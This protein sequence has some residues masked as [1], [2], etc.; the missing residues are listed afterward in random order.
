MNDGKFVFYTGPGT[1]AG[2]ASSITEKMRI[3]AD[4]N[5]GIGTT[6]ASQ[7]LEVAG[8]SPIIRVLATSGNSTLRLTDN[9]VRNWDLKVVDASDYFEVGGTNTTSLIVTGTGK[10]GIGVTN[11]TQ[12]L[13]V[14]GSY[15]TAGDDTGILKIRGGDTGADSQ[16]NFGVSADGGYGWIQTTDV[17]LSNDRSII[18]NPIGGNVG[19]GTTNP[20][21]NGGGLHVYGSGQKGIR[22]SGNS[23]NSYSVEIGCDATKMSYIQTVGTADRGL[24]LYTGN[25]S[26]VVMTL[27]GSSVGIGT[28]IPDAKL[29]VVSGEARIGSA[30]A[31]TTHLNYLNTGTNFISCANNGYTYFR[32]SGTF[33]TIMVIAGGTGNVGIGGSPSYK[34]DVN[35]GSNSFALRL[36]GS[37]VDGPV[38]RF[39][40]TGSTGRIY[41]VGST[42]TTSGAG[43]GFSIYDVTGNSARMLIDA[44][45]N[46]GIGTTA[47][48]AKLDVVGGNV[49]IR[50]D[51]SGGSAALYL[52]NWAGSPTTTMVFG[53]STGDDSSTSLSLNSNI[54][55]ITNYGDP[56]SYI[57]FGTRNNST[58][59]IRMCINQDGNVGIGTTNASNKLE[60]HGGIQLLNSSG[61]TSSATSGS[62]MIIG[63]NTA[64]S[65][66]VTQLRNTGAGLKVGNYGLL[67]D[68]GNVHL[69]STSPGTNIWL[70]CSG[71]GNFIINGQTGATGGVGI[72]TSTMSGYV[73][74]NG[75]STV[76]I[77]AYGYLIST[78]SPPTGTGA[79][80]TAN[81]S[82]TCTQRVQATEFDATSDERLK[83]IEGEIPLNDAVD[84]VNKV[85]PVKYKWKDGI[86]PSSKTGYSAQQVYKAGFDHL[87]SV[88]KKEGMEEIVESDG[89][90]NPKDAQFVM[91]YEQVT[92]YHSK[93]IK[94]LLD[95]I[96]QLEN[97][98][99]TLEDR[100]SVLESK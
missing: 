69:H 19:I 76:T 21:I 54:F 50:N 13:D 52:R 20:T 92:P 33:G 53:N 64:Q 62:L 44:N 94:H 46:L 70:N 95:K 96:E 32:D 22:I 99:E 39:E 71:S 55:S 85:I 60:V 12:K 36:L 83:N 40:N 100:L 27:T 23:S 1:T 93:L 18:L 73:T 31:F 61:S 41:H 57:R 80:T 26:T 78:G 34:L 56:G 37:S 4:G 14:V 8:S 79:G 59:D 7:L 48:A 58:S 91:N 67:F 51:A 5:V 81:Y 49:I 88:V 65:A 98:I 47:P 75:G 28:T 6:S 66:N 74:I 68:D 84:F 45:G 89:F 63:Q 2:A 90:I 9:G 30:V 38:I 87:V 24:Q 82:I 35:N 97:R 11:P 15:G 77:G 3:T 10:V 16:L 72:G 17:G 42:G 43:G 86:D 25:A 29:D